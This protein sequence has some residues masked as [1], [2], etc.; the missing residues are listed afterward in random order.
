MQLH[1]EQ[2]YSCIGKTVQQCSSTVQFDS[3]PVAAR[4]TDN[5]SDNLPLQETPV[6][7]IPL[8]SKKHVA[9]TLDSSSKIMWL[10]SNQTDST[11]NRT[12]MFLL[13][14]VFPGVRFNC[15][16]PSHSQIIHSP[17]LHE[18]YMDL[19]LHRSQWRT[20]ADYPVSPEGNLGQVL[21]ACRNTV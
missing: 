20:R 7:T 21:V 18:I 17:R 9:E 10:C 3:G 5:V 1:G 8:A 12:Q 6:T 2:S 15:A 14:S 11:I 16:T 19:Q 13:F 4:F